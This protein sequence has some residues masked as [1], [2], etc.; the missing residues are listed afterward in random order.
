MDG[1]SS[2][3]LLYAEAYNAMGLTRAVI[4]PSGAP[5]HGVIPRHQTVPLRQVNLPVTFGGQ[6]NFRMK[7]LTFKIADFPDAYQAILG[8]PCYTK[9][10]AIPNYTY[11]TLKM[12]S[13]HEIITIGGDL[14]Q[15]HLCERENYDIATA[16]CQPPE[17]RFKWATTAGAM[18][19]P[20]SEG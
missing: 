7:T 17:P 14:L 19:E 15:T 5:F 8:Q 1:G 12:P 11:L 9:F 20:S 13:P 4:R 3:N 2:L 16:G 6:A 10:I 18:P